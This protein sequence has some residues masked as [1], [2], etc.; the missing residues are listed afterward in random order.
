MIL[1]ASG[2]FSL[3]CAPAALLLY[4]RLTGAAIIVGA[5]SIA[6][7]WTALL[8]LQEDIVRDV[9]TDIGVM[10]RALPHYWRRAAGMGLLS[11]I[12]LL[13]GLVTLPNLALPE[14]PVVVW[15]GL[16]ADGLGILIVGSLSLYVFPLIALHDMS[17]G[18][19]LR[20][21]FLLAGRHVLNTIGLLSMGIIFTCAMV[22]IS[23]GLV[24]ILPAF[25]G[26]FIVNNCR[27]VV[28][29]ELAAQA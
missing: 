5:L 22:Y 28:Q 26:V 6:P 13:A 24:F 20:N 7:A 1:L 2:V 15:G 29:E 23:S 4:W 17:L 9:R 3:A 19:A 12:P 14:V 18:T 25:W 10:L 27:L 16:A 11:S 8:A 21:A